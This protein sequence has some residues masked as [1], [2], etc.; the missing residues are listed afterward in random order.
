MS[1]LANTISLSITFPIFI[2]SIL[3]VILKAFTKHQNLQLEVVDLI[4]ENYI[5]LHI[6]KTIWLYEQ[7]FTLCLET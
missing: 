1:I 7:V 4:A 2:L 5:I 6:A 3:I